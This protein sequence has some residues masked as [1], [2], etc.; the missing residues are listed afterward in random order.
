MH[1]LSTSDETTIVCCARFAEF[2]ICLWHFARFCCAMVCWLH[3]CVQ[4]ESVLA[5]RHLGVLLSRHSYSGRA[6]QRWIPLQQ[7][8]ECI[9]HEAVGYLKVTYYV[10]LIVNTTTVSAQHSQ[11]KQVASSV[12]KRQQ[13]LVLL[14]DVSVTAAHAFHQTYQPRC[15]GIHQSLSCELRVPAHAVYDCC[16]CCCCSCCC[17]ICCS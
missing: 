2:C 10:A 13:Q 7:I 3:R 9:I 14:F 16:C 6:I 12:S 1:S 15:C 11:A 5:V 8:E 17:C 4:P